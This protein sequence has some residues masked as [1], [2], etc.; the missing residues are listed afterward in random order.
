MTRRPCFRE[1][2]WTEEVDAALRKYVKAGH[3]GTQIAGILSHRFGG[4][5]T[6]SSVLG[7]CHRKGIKLRADHKVSVPSTIP[8]YG[9]PE[10]AASL[11]AHAR[12]LCLWPSG[13][14]PYSFECNETANIG[15]PY[16]AEHSRRAY[17]RTRPMEYAET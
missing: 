17:R 2:V 11:A 4:K 8:T 14:G 3:S 12:G 15:K 16:C 9:S 6:R 10:Q 1:T 5:F 7:R 13:E